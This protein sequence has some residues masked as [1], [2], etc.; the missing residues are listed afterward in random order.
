MSELS[1]VL[2]EIPIEISFTYIGLTTWGDSKTLYDEWRI[3]LSY[4]NKTLETPY[5]SGIGH[6]VPKKQMFGTKQRG[7]DL[8]DSPEGMITTE[9][10]AKKGLL[11]PVDP[12]VEDVLACLFCDASSANETFEDW[13][14]NYG[15]DTDSIKALDTYLQCQKSRKDLIKMLGHELFEK[16][17]LLEH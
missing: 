17:S 7:I 9:M 8:W 13:C 1:D 5:R 16:L 11:V 12:K 2:K 14:S 15:Y 6:R 3:T 10:A 4:D